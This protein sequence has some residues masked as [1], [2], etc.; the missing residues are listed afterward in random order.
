MWREFLLKGTLIIVTLTLWS[1]ITLKVHWRLQNR[2][3]IQRRDW[4]KN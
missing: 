1:W 2:N 3:K 4:S